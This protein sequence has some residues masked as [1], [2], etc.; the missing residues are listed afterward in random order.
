MLKKFRI[1]NLLSPPAP[2]AAADWLC[3][4]PALR[5]LFFFFYSRKDPPRRAG[6]QAAPHP[7]QRIFYRAKAQRRK[8]IVVRS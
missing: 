3:A 2:S 6:R 4:F 7:P 8:E 5:A 1:I